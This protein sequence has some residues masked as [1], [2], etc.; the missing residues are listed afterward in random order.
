MSKQQCTSCGYTQQTNVERGYTCQGIDA[1]EC[2]KCRK[3]TLIFVDKYP[4]E[5]REGEIGYKRIF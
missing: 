5:Y 3:W 1:R 4:D 2:P